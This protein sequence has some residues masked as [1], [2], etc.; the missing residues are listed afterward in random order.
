VQQEMSNVLRL[1]FQVCLNFR[2]KRFINAR[3]LRVAFEGNMAYNIMHDVAHDPHVMA[4]HLFW[5]DQKKNN[6]SV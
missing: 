4:A 1:C 6:K 5:H 2:P 3:K